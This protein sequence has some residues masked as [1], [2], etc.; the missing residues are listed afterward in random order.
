MS[1]SNITDEAR[2]LRDALRRYA[3]QTLGRDRSIA[4]QL[5]E[6]I[7]DDLTAQDLSAL[8]MLINTKRAA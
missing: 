1:E 2:I 6:V 5:A 3:A 4:E 8:P 7:P